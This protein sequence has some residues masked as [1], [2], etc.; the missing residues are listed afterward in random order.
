[1][2]KINSKDNIDL[3][4][5]IEELS[6]NFNKLAYEAAK[7]VRL[8]IIRDHLS[9]N[10]V[11]SLGKRTGN[12]QSDLKVDVVK[13]YGSFATIEVYVPE[14]A[15]SFIYGN[16]WENEK[17]FWFSKAIEDIKIDRE[18]QPILNKASDLTNAK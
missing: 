1:M 15:S 12:L 8:D 11:N 16:R 10:G 14:T 4:Q 7:E 17:Y 6:I 3:N 2:I 9:I 18:F 13:N 5:A